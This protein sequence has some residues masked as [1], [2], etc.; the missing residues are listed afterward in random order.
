MPAVG[1]EAPQRDG[2]TRIFCRNRTDANGSFHSFSTL[3]RGEDPGTPPPH[4]RRADPRP[5]PAASR[6][7]FRRV[8]AQDCR[9]RST[10]HGAA[11]PG[12]GSFSSPV[13]RALLA[14]RAPLVFCFCV[15]AHLLDSSPAPRAAPARFSLFPQGFSRSEPLASIPAAAPVSRRRLPPADLAPPRAHCAPH[16]PH[17]AERSLRC[18]PPLRRFQPELGAGW[19]FHLPREVS[20]EEWK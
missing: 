9:V 15:R 11:L 17:V 16:M 19:C 6:A 14:T 1:G 5:A 10:A 4:L 12:A 13:A 8:T 20:Y 7:A 3:P 18:A 2:R